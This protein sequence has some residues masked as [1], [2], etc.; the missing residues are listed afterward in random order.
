MTKGRKHPDYIMPV[1]MPMARLSQCKMNC[2]GC[3]DLLLPVPITTFADQL[4]MLI[5]VFD[6]ITMSTAPLLLYHFE[7]VLLLYMFV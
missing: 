2:E 3:S 7:F 4:F 1:S 6:Y 5:F